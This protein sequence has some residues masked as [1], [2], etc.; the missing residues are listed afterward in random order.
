M[1]KLAEDEKASR[2]AHILG[3]ALRCFARTGYHATTI[4]DIAAEAGVSKGAPYVYFES[5]EA[6]F[7][8]L[9]D[10]W[11]CGVADKI[12]QEL[13]SLDVDE[14][15][16]PRTVLQAIVRALGRQ[17]REEPDTC[18][19]LM[20]ARTLAAYVA[21][22]AERVRWSQAEAQA[23]MVELVNVG[24]ARREWPRGTD[25]ELQARLILA[26]IHG[27]MAE[28]HLGPHS[29]SWDEAAAALANRQADRPPR[30]SSPGRARPTPDEFDHVE[31]PVS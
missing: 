18:R 29:F 5:K 20:E 15:R 26:A 31:V 7:R 19:V 2:R 23:R 25:V 8:A 9:Y 6:L 21:G 4:D 27:L 22:I 12:E 14:R 17:V 3:A 1:P 11:D 30:R 28:W 16:S 13:A 10:S 24:V